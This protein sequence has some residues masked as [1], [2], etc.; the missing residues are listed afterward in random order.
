MEI[1]YILLGIVFG[2]ICGW[3]ARERLAVRTIEK[4]YELYEEK[5]EEDNSR[6]FI[7]IEV[8]NGTIFIYNKI[9]KE[10]MAQGSNTKEIEKVLISKY[11]GKHFSTSEQELQVLRDTL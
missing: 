6:I 8:D 11:P 5:E 1:L 7:D 4:L 2:I 10:F 3:K 9:T